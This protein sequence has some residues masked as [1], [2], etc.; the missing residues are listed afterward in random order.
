M[1]IDE[2]LDYIIENTSEMKS[3]IARIEEQNLQ[4]YNDREDHGT[5]IKALES[6]SDK[7]SG[8]ISVI[9]W[10]VGAFGTAEIINIIVTLFHR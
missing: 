5:S 8:A 10:L 6:Q 4:C 1:G 3:S 9:K 2:K 7:A